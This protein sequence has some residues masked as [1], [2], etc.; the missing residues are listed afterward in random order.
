MG[1]R[2]GPERARDREE[3]AAVDVLKELKRTEAM[4]V[5]PGKYVKERRCWQSKFD[6]MRV[7]RWNEADRR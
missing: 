2:R 7:G 3:M 4:D 6:R 5:V 1:R